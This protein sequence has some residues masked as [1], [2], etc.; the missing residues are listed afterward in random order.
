MCERNSFLREKAENFRAFL[1]GQHPDADLTARIEGFRDDM[2][3]PTLTTV[4]LPAIAVRGVEG[5]AI[6]MMT[7]LKPEDASTVKAKLERYIT[8]F[9]EVLT[10]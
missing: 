3:L 10:E 2:L 9:Y 8:L 1:L 4:L 6:E 7:H 5:V